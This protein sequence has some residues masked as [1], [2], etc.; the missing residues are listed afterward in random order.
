MATSVQTFRKRQNIRFR[1]SQRQL[2]GK[3]TLSS[4]AISEIQWWIRNIDNFYHNINIPNSD[5]IIQADP[6][7]TGW[8]FTDGIS[9]SRG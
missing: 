2:S 6:S 1:K 3:I 9:L 4:K 5:I 8:T 7:L